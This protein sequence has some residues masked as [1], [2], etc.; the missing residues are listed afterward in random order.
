MMNNPKLNKFGQ[1]ICV[2]KVLCQCCP[3]KFDYFQN[4]KDNTCFNGYLRAK[5]R[6]RRKKV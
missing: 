1:K 4:G 2:L 3:F 5:R 6:Y